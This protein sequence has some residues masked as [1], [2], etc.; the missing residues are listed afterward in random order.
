MRSFGDRAR[1]SSKWI[2]TH[3]VKVSILEHQRVPGGRF[4]LT[5]RA[6]RRFRVLRT[7]EIDGYR[8]ASVA[9]AKDDVPKCAPAMASAAA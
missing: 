9:W 8:N 7:W 5:V 3:G 2:A 4:L 6:E 1:A